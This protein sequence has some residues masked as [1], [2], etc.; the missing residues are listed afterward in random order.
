MSKTLEIN[1]D[2]AFVYVCE[3]LNIAIFQCTMH[4]GYEVIISQMWVLIN[5][6]FFELACWVKVAWKN[7]VKHEVDWVMPN[8]ENFSIYGI[9][10]IYSTYLT[11]F[12]SLTCFTWFSISQ[13]PADNFCII[14]V[15]IPGGNSSPLCIQTQ[16]QCSFISVFT[17]DQ[18]HTAMNAVTC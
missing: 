15:K 12:P 9:Y 4:H 17:I 13:H 10:A 16:L 2:S 11:V 5:I 18:S 3:F 7:S 8:H 6:L 1:L 14:V